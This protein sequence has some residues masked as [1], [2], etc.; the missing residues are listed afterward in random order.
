MTLTMQAL[1]SIKLIIGITVSLAVLAWILI[2]GVGGAYLSSNPDKAAAYAFGSMN[3]DP[4][5]GFLEQAGQMIQGYKQAD[6]SL[7][8][9]KQIEAEAEAADEGFSRRSHEFIEERYGPLSETSGD[10]P[11]ETAPVSDAS[12]E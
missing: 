11:M 3:V 9:L 4:N 5:A 8:E 2:G 7:T 12:F 6:K 1:R 10:E